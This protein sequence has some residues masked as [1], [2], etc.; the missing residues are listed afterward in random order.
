[1]HV[2]SLFWATRYKSC[3]TTDMN[4]H[5]MTGMTQELYIWLCVIWKVKLIKC[6]VHVA[7]MS[8]IKGYNFYD[9]IL[10]MTALFF[11]HH[12]VMPNL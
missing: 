8:T 3:M 11:S 1:M 5:V 10:N 12:G 4:S 9:P 7:S 6:Y 2:V